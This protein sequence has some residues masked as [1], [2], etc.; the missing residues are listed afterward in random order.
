MRKTG[1]R[2]KAAGFYLAVAVS[3]AALGAA[4]W[5]ASAE[6]ETEEV[7]PAPQLTASVPSSEAT[8][9]VLIPKRD[10]PREETPSRPENYV[11][12]YPDGTEPRAQLSEPPAE[13]LSQTAELPA[14]VETAAPA[15]NIPKEEP[16]LTWASPVEGGRVTNPYSGG[17]L[18]KSRTLGEWRTHDGIDISAAEGDPVK[19]A[20]DG[21]V[22]DV[23]KDSRWGW[24][25]EAEHGDVTVLYCGLDEA[26]K[27]AA[28]Q[29]LKQG[30][31]IGKVGNS[32]VME[33]SEEPHLHLS[34]KQSGKW[35][36]PAEVLGF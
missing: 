30:D 32:S 16:A 1:M 13:E 23:R 28:G 19:A 15:E 29:Q 12:S 11:V 20:A 6:L 26:V 17:E 4:A 2:R 36:D 33:A 14:E 35:I 18:V 5:L 21:V 10:V 7:Q 24:V 8:E 31:I 25:I 3:A 9:E 27:T 34:M 22:K